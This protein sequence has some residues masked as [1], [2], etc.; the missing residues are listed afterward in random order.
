MSSFWS[1]KEYIFSWTFKT[2]WSIG[3]YYIY[4]LKIQRQLNF[5]FQQILVTNVFCLFFKSLNSNAYCPC[6]V[7]ATYTVFDLVPFPVPITV[8]VRLLF[9]FLAQFLFLVLLL[10][11][12]SS[13]CLFCCFYASTNPDY[14]VHIPVIFLL[15]IP[16]FPVLVFLYVPVPCS[17]SWLCFVFLFL[18]VL[19]IPKFFLYMLLF[20]LCSGFWYSCC[21]HS[22]QIRI[23]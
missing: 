4:L 5:T 19:L 16:F 22:I 2:L 21:F 6:F 1:S 10:Y 9:L 18:F 23:E 14:S 11:S 3:Y 20:R 8:S 15:L 17:C 13:S 12:G 7:P